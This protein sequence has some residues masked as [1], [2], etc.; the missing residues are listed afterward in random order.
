MTDQISIDQAVRDLADIKRAIDHAQRN[1][2]GSQGI[3]IAGL[4]VVLHV[5][6][7]AAAL[8]CLLLAIFFRPEF[9]AAFMGAFENWS[10]R[11][12]LTGIVTAVTLVGTFFFYGL[13]WRE[14][15]RQS[16]SFEQYVARYFGYLR[17]L[18]FLSDLFIKFTGVSLVILAGRPDWVAPLLCI[19]TGDYLVQGRFFVLPIKVALGLGLFCIIFGAI[20][21]ALYNLE[22]DYALM[23]FIGVAAGS[24]ANILLMR[25][26]QH[27]AV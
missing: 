27:Q 12:W 17:N 22:I 14:A 18:S 3:S 24:L 23:L 2:S 11:F 13:V 10:S 9:N 6:A 25:R 26:K 16:E 19:F 21:L 7:L 1:T 8:L 4:H 20:N 5:L 15:R